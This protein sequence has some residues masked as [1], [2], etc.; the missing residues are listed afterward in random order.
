MDH[1]KL[2]SP[3][4]FTRR[5]V[6]SRRIFF[7]TTWPLNMGPTG[8]PETSVNNYQP[9]LRIILEGRRSQEAGLAS[10]PV[11][12]IWKRDKT[13]ASAGIRNL[14]R[15]ACSLV[16]IPTTK[17]IHSLSPSVSQG[18][19]I[20]QKSTNHFN[21]LGFRMMTWSKLGTQDS[22]IVGANTQNVVATVFWRRGFVHLC[23]KHLFTEMLRNCRIS[24]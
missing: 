24:T 7:W 10:Q 19:Q 21:I 12:T 17:L 20:F 11:W 1:L 6:H 5:P 16:T 13:A 9:T 3:L 18:P 4:F 15:P 8:C 23:C 2:R 14:D 22:Q